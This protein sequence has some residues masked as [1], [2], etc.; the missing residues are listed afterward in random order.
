MDSRI[1]VLKRGTAWDD[2]QLLLEVASPTEDLWV[3]TKDIETVSAVWEELTRD[4]ESPYK[5]GR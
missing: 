2:H 3:E 1:Q 5:I 4:Q